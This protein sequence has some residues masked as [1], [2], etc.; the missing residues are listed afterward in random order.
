MPGYIFG[1]T[2]NGKAENQPKPLL[3]L[4]FQAF[5]IYSVKYFQLQKS[6]CFIVPIPITKYPESHPG[7][8]GYKGWKITKAES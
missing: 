1:D 6:K 3:R 8:A 5:C 4:K 2:N 7:R